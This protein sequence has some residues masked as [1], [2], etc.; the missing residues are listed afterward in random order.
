LE[1]IGKDFEDLDHA[2]VVLKASDKEID[3]GDIRWTERI[4]LSR[5]GTGHRSL[6]EK[7]RRRLLHLLL[8]A[9]A[10]GRAPVLGSQTLLLPLYSDTLP[11]QHGRLLLLHKLH[12]LEE[13]L[14]EHAR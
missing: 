4:G 12:A 9:R 14:F 6:V 1:T 3:I 11:L 8:E 13:M 2:D 10:F 7:H 5:F